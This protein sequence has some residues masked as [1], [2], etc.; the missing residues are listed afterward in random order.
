M[1]L[2][3]KL[4]GTEPGRYIC[5]GRRPEGL[6]V[7]ISVILETTHH[8]CKLECLPMASQALL[9]ASSH[10][11][12]VPP[13]AQTTPLSIFITW[14]KI[15]RGTRR[16]TADLLNQ[17]IKK[18]G[19]SRPLSEFSWPPPFFFIQVLQVLPQD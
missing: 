18:A 16:V 1:E 11:E 12:S 17:N 3:L 4:S 6:K 2:H 9:P 19:P 7:E 15:L 13:P 8:Q 10:S 14:E 5:W